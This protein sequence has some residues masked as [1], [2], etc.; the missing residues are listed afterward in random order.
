MALSHPTLEQTQVSEGLL[1]DLLGDF[2]GDL[3]GDLLGGRAGLLGAFELLR[4]RHQLRRALLQLR[5]V[6]GLI[7]NLA[8]RDRRLRKASAAIGSNQQPSGAIGSHQ[9]PSEAIGSHRKPS[10]AIG[11]H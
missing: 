9:E 11:S 3:L 2:L 7:D 10:G 5:E 1:G 4:L 8:R 6:L